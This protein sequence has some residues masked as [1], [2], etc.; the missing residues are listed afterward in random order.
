MREGAK[1]SLS[2]QTEKK[3][4]RFE[5]VD[6]GAKNICFITANLKDIMD[7]AGKLFN[8]YFLKE[9]KTFTIIF[10]R[11]FNNELERESTINAL[12]K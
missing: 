6:T 7:G 10:N 12:P 11:R 8:W 1:A 5:S 3:K 4:F 9:L 2:G